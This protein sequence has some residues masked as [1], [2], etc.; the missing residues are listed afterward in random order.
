MEITAT[1]TNEIQR[2]LNELV[3]TL[4][5]LKIDLGRTTQRAI[6][7]WKKELKESYS[8]M[9]EER[10]KITRALEEREREHSQ[11][12]EAERLER[13]F[14]QEDQM[15]R[16]M[17]Q[18]DKELFEE[19][20]KAELRMTERKLEMERAAKS[21]KARLPELKVKITPFDGTP[22]DWIRFENMFVS[23]IHNKNISVEEKFG[24]LL[25][26]VE[27]RVK[28]RLANLKP[29]GMGYKTAWDG[30]GQAQG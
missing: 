15:R 28:D 11:Q 30:Q 21:V 20:M 18:R 19:R 26:L 8:P 9:L 1:R 6:R 13:K 17:Q 4:Q 12:A 7:Q 23:Q 2:H 29:S 24:Y 16:E 5:E 10:A 25:E 14:K 27:K 22:G 3:S